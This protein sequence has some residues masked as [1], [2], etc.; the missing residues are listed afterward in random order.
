VEAVQMGAPDSQA[1]QCVREALT[2]LR[3]VEELEEPSKL[4]VLPRR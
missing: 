1:L 4:S 3:G 2:D